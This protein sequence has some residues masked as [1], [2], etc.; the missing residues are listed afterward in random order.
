MV[1]ERPDPEQY[2]RKGK[3]CQN[4]RVR[5][6]QEFEL[7]CRSVSGVVAVEHQEDG[8]YI[9]VRVKRDLYNAARRVVFRKMKENGRHV[10][11]IWSR[12]SEP[13]PSLPILDRQ[14][15]EFETFC[16]GTPGVLAVELD[17]IKRKTYIITIQLCDRNPIW[18]RIHRWLDERHLS[19]SY[20]HW[21]MVHA[22][23]P[24]AYDALDRAISNPK[25]IHRPGS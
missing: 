20:I 21:S 6:D 3:P 14:D 22:T 23:T 19:H 12:V 25:Y 16:K 7:F 18:R 4:G 10:P 13:P 5:T 1:K 24:S 11:L 17:G 15:L 9:E 2:S 8:Q